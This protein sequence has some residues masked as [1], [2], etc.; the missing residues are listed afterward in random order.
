VALA[1]SDGS[2]C[3]PFPLSISIGSAQINPRTP[4]SLDELLA[5]ADQAMYVQKTARRE[6]E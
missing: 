2:N 5:Q 6:N 1:E 3:L 4:G